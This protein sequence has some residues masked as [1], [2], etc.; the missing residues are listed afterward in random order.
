[1][2]PLKSKK[3]VLAVSVSCFLFSAFYFAGAQTQPQFMVSWQAGNYAPN[4]YEGKILPV[5]GTAVKASF[6]LVDNGKIADLSKIKI[7][8]YVNGKLAI[9]EDSGLGIKNYEFSVSGYA[10]Q[11]A[12]VR[13]V[14]VD[15]PSGQIDKIVNI[16][17]VKPD[18]VINIPYPE[19]KIGTGSSIFELFPFFFNIKN[20]GQLSPDWSINGQAPAGQGANPFILDLNVGPETPSSA[21]I[22]VSAS[23][24]NVSNNLEFSN[25]TVQLQIK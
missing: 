9:N 3:F 16:P 24:K 11:N 13:I 20:L 4:W 7:R 6:E 18:A 5:K 15:Y 25:K 10:G 22:G 23:V 21:K 2:K 17:I 1:M 12:E 19:S 14:A 8:W